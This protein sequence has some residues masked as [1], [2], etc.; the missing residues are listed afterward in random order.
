M[1]WPKYWSFSLSISPANEYPG[2]T[3]LQFFLKGKSI[4]EVGK[5]DRVKIDG[6]QVTL[7]HFG[8]ICCEESFYEALD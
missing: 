2:L 3:S 1:R 8:L 7:K 5:K 4:A 6:C